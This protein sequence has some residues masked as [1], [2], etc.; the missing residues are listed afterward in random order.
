M[1]PRRREAP[2]AR[3]AATRRRAH[4]LARRLARGRRRRAR[5]ALRPPLRAA[6]RSALAAPERARR[7]GERRRRPRTARRGAPT[8]PATTSSCASTPSGRLRGSTSGADRE[9]DPQPLLRSARTRAA[10]AGQDPRRPRRV[11][12]ARVR[13]AAWTLLGIFAG[14][15]ARP[16][17]ALV[18]LAR[19]PR[20]LAALGVTTDFA[21][22]SGLMFVYSWEPAQPLRALL[23]LVILEAALFFRLVGGLIA[24]LAT[25]PVLLALEYW[26][27]DE[28]GFPS[29]GTHSCFGSSSASRSDS[30]SGGSS[31]WSAA[32]R[33]T[34]T[35][36]PQRPS[37]C[38]TS[39]VAASTCSRRPAV[40]PARS[41]RRSTSTRLSPPSCASCAA[42]VPFDRAAI[43]LAEGGGA[44]VMATAGI[45]AEDYLEPGTAITVPGSILEAVIADGATIYREDIAEE[46]FPEE[47]GLLALG[48]RSR[49]L[50]PL[51][52]G[53][54]SIGALAI[55]RIEPAS[56]REE[57]VELVTLLG[58]LV[59]TA[60]QNLRTYE[61]ER[62][63]VEEL[64][65]L[66]ALRAD[67]VSLVSHEL[68]SP[69]AAVIGSART[70]QAR[71]R[72]L[73][74]EQR[75]AFLAVIADETTRLSALV[76]DVLDTSR[77]EAGTFGYRSPTS[78]W[79]RCCAT[80]SPQPR[81]ARTKCSSRPSCRRRC[82]SCAATR[83]AAPARRQPDLER[84][85]VLGLR[86]RGRGSRPARR[87]ARDRP[88]PRRG[89]RDPRRTPGPDLREVRPRRRPAK[90][91]TGLGLFLSRSFAE[92]HGGSLDVESRPG[93]G[94]IFTLTSPGGLAGELDARELQLAEELRARASRSRA[95]A[96]AGSSTIASPRSARISPISQS[97]VPTRS[98]ARA[99]PSV[100]LVAPRSTR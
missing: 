26:R 24:G 44:R 51:Q 86:R 47:A 9:A 74:P 16:A 19:P 23:F 22:T 94:A 39:S 52:L 50:A 95:G 14:L 83:P 18:S 64:R 89:T 12:D 57:E 78:I 72:E 100:S 60:V 63:T 11:P 20:Y 41:A 58:R 59:A 79:P 36:E 53:T 81:S 96:S 71:W 40:P 67:F 91:G 21:V 98:V 31:T 35:N 2:C 46:R 1:E 56:F 30:S 66:S 90:P 27:H 49:V 32:R 73:R 6:E 97:S 54:R 34:P 84:D 87:R 68:R 69:M 70:L 76:G 15:G 77:I 33:T 45:G 82:P 93:E 38:A 5:R 99:E 92:A 25:L 55:S 42:C 4:R 28:F 7:R 13:A 48:V 62:A 65:R 8:R 85:Q 43:L 61:A 29:A 17:R 80:R 88:R 10:G 37:A 3:G 75:E